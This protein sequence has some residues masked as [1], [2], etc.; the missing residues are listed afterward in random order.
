LRA[1]R[2]PEDEARGSLR[3]TTGIRSTEANVE[4]LLDVL[5]GIVERVREVT[6]ELSAVSS[7]PSASLR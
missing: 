4:R 1:L 6:T 3:L 5:P 7:Q 2:L